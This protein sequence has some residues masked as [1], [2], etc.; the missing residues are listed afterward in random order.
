MD[1][2][3]ADDS[4]LNLSSRFGLQGS[5]N[6]AEDLGEWPRRTNNGRAKG[7]V[8][9]IRAITQTICIGSHLSPAE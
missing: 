2:D 1:I 9:D 3:S 5:N 6:A 8:A 7:E 4:N